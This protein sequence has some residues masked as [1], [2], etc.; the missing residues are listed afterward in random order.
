MRRQ[1]IRR[2][3]FPPSAAGI[4]AASGVLAALV[5]GCP[6]PEDMGGGNGSGDSIEQQVLDVVDMLV[7]SGDLSGTTGPSG[8]QGPAGDAGPTGDTG[9]QGPTGSQGAIGPQGAQGDPGASPFSLMGS[10]AVY[11]DGNV[12]IGTTTPAVALDVDGDI[13]STGTVSADAFSSNSALQ[14]QT[15]GATRVYVDD[16][17]GTVGIGTI[18]PSTFVALH[19]AG[20]VHIRDADAGVTISP[21]TDR[22]NIAYSIGG[23][24][25]N[26]AD[27]RFSTITTNN[28]RVGIRRQ[29]ATNDLE[30]Q[31]N[32]SKAVAGSWLA[33]SD[34]RIKTDVQKV[35]HALDTLD[36][37]RLVQFR[38]TDDYR[39]RNPSIKDHAYLN[40]IAQEFREVFPNH[41]QGSGEKLPNG[42]E[43]LQVDTYPLTIYSA[44]AIQELHAMVRDRDLQIAGQ[45][46]RI[47]ELT[48]HDQSQTDRVAELEQRLARLEAL[49]T[50]RVVLGD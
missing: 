36:K 40:V 13:H 12:G 3:S 18:T 32:A 44:A 24:G 33:N 50:E 14:L 16:T 23:G 45:Q 29:P 6:A 30:V 9:P 25:S 5:V 41:V 38:Y 31:G 21:L 17:S 15:A 28:A 27:I 19:V 46:Q 34:A 47:E 22:V 26:I 43:I 35:A 1:N 39:A 49:M 42:S 7:D 2:N 11:T 20:A 8:P 10:D 37:V 4:L 48:S